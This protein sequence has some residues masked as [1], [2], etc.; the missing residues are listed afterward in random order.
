MSYPRLALSIFAIPNGGVRHLGTARMLKNE[1]VTA[2]V[3]DLFIAVPRGTFGGM[4]VEIKAGKNKL[5]DT[6]EAFR[7]ANKKGYNFAV[8]YSL[9]EFIEAVNKYLN[10]KH[11]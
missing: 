8:C 4:F 7:E 3:W 2:G 10:T 11:I 1:G 5:T 6:Q 9:D